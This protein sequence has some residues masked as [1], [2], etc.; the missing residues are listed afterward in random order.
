MG[1]GVV[2]SD[3]NVI[4]LKSPLFVKVTD[5][6]ST[7]ETSPSGAGFPVGTWVRQIAECNPSFRTDWGL[8]LKD[9]TDSALT[10]PGRR[11]FGNLPKTFTDLIGV[12]ER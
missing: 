9:G 4:F 2:Q 7:R 10:F 5:L 3:V 12:N 8:E 1:R 11:F 6:T